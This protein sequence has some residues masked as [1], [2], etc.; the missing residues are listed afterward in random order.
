MLFTGGQDS[1]A[2]FGYLFRNGGSINIPSE[3]VRKTIDRIFVSPSS[4][5]LVIDAFVFL[6]FQLTVSVVK[7]SAKVTKVSLND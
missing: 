6:F 2:F 1:V 3:V 5:W 7:K 4:S